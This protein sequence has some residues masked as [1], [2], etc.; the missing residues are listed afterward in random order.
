M[1]CYVISFSVICEIG[2]VQYNPYQLG[3][4]GPFTDLATPAQWSDNTSPIGL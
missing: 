4:I 3:G 1:D 2:R